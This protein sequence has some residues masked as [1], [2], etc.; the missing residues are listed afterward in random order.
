MCDCAGNSKPR[1]L[2]LPVNK[3][4]EVLK[5]TTGKNTGKNTNKNTTGKNNTVNDKAN[6][7]APAEKTSK[8]AAFIASL[9]A[10]FL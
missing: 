6:N 1:N 10:K 8:T 2:T 7:T 3:K 5:N 4:V 9:F